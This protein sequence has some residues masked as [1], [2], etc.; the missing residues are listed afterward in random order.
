M[1]TPII[2]SVFAA[3]GIATLAQPASA[4]PAGYEPAWIQGNM[5]CKIKT[6]KLNLK[7]NQGRQIQKSSTFKAKQVGQPPRRA[8]NMQ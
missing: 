2:A 6:P 5:V 1:R 3:I 8:V 4:C 7:A